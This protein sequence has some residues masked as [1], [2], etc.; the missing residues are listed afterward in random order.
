[1]F[2]RIECWKAA[3]YAVYYYPMGVGPWGL[4]RVLE[5]SIAVTPTTELRMFFDMDIFGLKCM[6]ANIMAETGLI[7]LGLLGFW[8]W[9]NFAL[10]ARTYY[11]LGTRLGLLISG[12]YWASAFIAVGLLFSCELYPHFAFMILLKFH[13]DTVAKA[14]CGG[15]C[16]V[17]G[18]LPAV[19]GSGTDGGDPIIDVGSSPLPN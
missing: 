6:L 5:H 8:L 2:T 18:V 11:R 17:A 16:A 4:G 15:G 10:P 13:A 19:S 9:V 7:G 1:M 14:C 3:F 12:L